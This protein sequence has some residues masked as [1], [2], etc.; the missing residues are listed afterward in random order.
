MVAD[1]AVGVAVDEEAEDGVAMVTGNVVVGTGTL[2]GR[3][4][5]NNGKRGMRSERRGNA[6]WSLM[7]APLLASGERLRLRC[8]RLPRQ[9]EARRKAGSRS[10]V[11]NPKQN[12][13]LGCCIYGLRGLGRQQ[14]CKD[15][16]IW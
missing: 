1:E 15:V 6:L 5:R 11:V 7:V 9:K 4:R 14:N 3:K 2:S 13:M 10:L 16:C 12:K 8:L